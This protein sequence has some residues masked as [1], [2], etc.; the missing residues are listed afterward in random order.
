MSGH[1]KNGEFTIALY[2]HIDSNNAADIEAELLEI[3]KSNPEGKLVLDA[4]KVDYISS[5][6]LRIILR[7][8]KAE[9]DVKIINVKPAVYEIF[10]TTGFTDMMP[11]EKAF[12][13]CR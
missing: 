3:R 1:Y 13:N 10:D 4:A 8:L 2:Y 9:K 6:G 7:L 11:V 5:A 12:G